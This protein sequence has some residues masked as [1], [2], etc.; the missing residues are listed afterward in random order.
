MDRLKDAEI[1][2]LPVII[3][4]LV[5][6]IVLLIVNNVS[7]IKHVILLYPV[8]SLILIMEFSNVIPV[9]VLLVHLS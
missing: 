8:S 2:V 9:N 5:W 4:G 1:V 7:L 3:L 6:Q